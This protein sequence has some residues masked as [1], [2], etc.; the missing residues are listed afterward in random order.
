MKLALFELSS[1]HQSFLREAQ[2]R[3]NLPLLGREA[4]K[5]II[6]DQIHPLPPP[7]GDSIVADSDAPTA[8]SQ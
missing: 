4:V 8:D 6:N 3:S 5:A 1:L 2:R 7:A